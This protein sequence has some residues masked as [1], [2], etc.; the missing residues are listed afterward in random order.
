MYQGKFPEGQNDFARCNLKI[1]KQ[2]ACG[3]PGTV[4]GPGLDLTCKQQATV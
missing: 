1:S 4:Q 2:S 3:E